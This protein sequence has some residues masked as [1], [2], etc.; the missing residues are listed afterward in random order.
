M[1]LMK[2]NDK[3]LSE[4][5]RELFK[6][7]KITIGSITD[8]KQKTF[9]GEVTHVPMVTGITWIRGPCTLEEEN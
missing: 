1:L 5:V 2:R 6:A 7:A 8:V 9:F 4:F 3:N